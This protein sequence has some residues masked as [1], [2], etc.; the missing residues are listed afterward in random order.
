NCVRGY[1]NYDILGHFDYIDRYLLDHSQDLKYNSLYPIIQE[2]LQL[3]IDNGKGLEL[4]TSGLVWGRDYFHPK[5][6]ILKLYKELGV[7][8]I[9]IGSNAHS[10]DYVGYEF[11]TAEKMLK[12]LG[13]KYIYI[14]KKRKKIPINIG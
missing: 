13:F 12:E 7:E 10:P 1:D 5:I 3:V 4:N 2:I 6:Q 11:R 9:T 14:F 8:I